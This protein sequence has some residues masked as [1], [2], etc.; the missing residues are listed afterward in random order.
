[1]KNVYFDVT[2]D[3]W[4]VSKKIKGRQQNFGKYNDVSDAQSVRDCLDNRGWTLKN[5]FDIQEELFGEVVSKRL[6]QNYNK[7]SEKIYG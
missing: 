7:R 1:M 3:K 6:L 4:I 5:L 2:S